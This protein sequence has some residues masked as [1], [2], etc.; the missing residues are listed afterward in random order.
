MS[1][2]KCYEAPVVKKIRLEVK[3][4]VLATCHTSYDATPRS[5]GVDLPCYLPPPAGTGCAT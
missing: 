3:N 2:K 5:L 1:D 4:A